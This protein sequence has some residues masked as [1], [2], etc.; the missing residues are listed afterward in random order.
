MKIQPTSH[1]DQAKPS[2]IVLMMKGMQLIVI[3]AVALLL[4]PF[5][6]VGR[7]IWERPPN[8]VHLAQVGRYLRLA[9][10]V[11]PPAPGLS[12]QGRL[13]LTLTI[14]RQ[15][16]MTPILGMAW[17]LDELLY[18]RSLNKLAIINPLFVISGGR[19]GSTQITRYIEADPH[20]TAPSLLQCM[21]PYLWLWKL[22][23]RTIGRLFPPEM[24]QQR[25]EAMMPPE[26]LE[27]HEF[28]PFKADTFDGAFFTAHLNPHA[29]YLGP[30]ISSTEF[31]F[32][33]FAP[34]ERERMEND[35]VRLVDRIGRKQL[36]FIGATQE[37]QPR[38]FIKGHF[39]CAADA[40][41]RHY[42]NATFLTVIRDPAD[43]LQSGI[44]YLQVNPSDPAMGPP[45]WGWLAASLLQSESDYCRIEQAWYTQPD[46]P[47]R[48]VI[49]FKD[50]VND[51]EGVMAQVYKECF[52]QTEL[53]PH[54]PRT[55]PP[56]NRTNYTV[57]RSLAELG[58]DAE[59]LRDE[60]AEYVAWCQ[61]LSD[62]KV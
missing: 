58:I 12:W 14:L 60:L 4:L 40:L 13:W 48:C 19:S 25:L 26:L 37:T 29:F 22:A 8:G 28:D 15:W 3:A 53:P 56:R 23:P 45:P 17:L 16:V 54:V 24:V 61:P 20:V 31:S 38:L 1:E 59:A 51:L 9:W 32:A 62:Q 42:P 39:L 50:F 5:Y 41:A 7:L 30:D 52:D 47:R 2:I 11:E 57:N 27:R 18:G 6:L 49:R 36:L 43:R 46:G 35:F 10:Q 21:F 55:H 33:A 34:H 44:N